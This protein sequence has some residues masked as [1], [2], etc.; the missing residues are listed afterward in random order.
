MPLA[1]L[2]RIHSSADKYAEKTYFNH[3]EVNSQD[4]NLVCMDNT[5]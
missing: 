3:E 2:V 4:L 1:K 5:K